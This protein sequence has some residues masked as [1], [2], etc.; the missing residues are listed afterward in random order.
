MG[1]ICPNARNS[2]GEQICP[3]ILMIEGLSTQI[4]ISKAGGVAGIG[5]FSEDIDPDGCV[6]KT[7]EIMGREYC[8]NG[9][10]GCAVYEMSKK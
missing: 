2:K 5:Y 8:R 1:D 9:G 6:S 4:D 10:E 7:R 3:A